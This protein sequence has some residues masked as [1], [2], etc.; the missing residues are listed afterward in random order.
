MYSKQGDKIFKLVEVDTQSLES[1]VEEANKAVEEAIAFRDEKIA[2]LKGIQK[3]VP[4][5]DSPIL[6]TAEQAIIN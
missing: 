2:E 1:Q 4:D 3:D 5:F 6:A